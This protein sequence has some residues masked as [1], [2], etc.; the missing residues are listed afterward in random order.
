LRW[1]VVTVLLVSVVGYSLAWAD[2]VDLSLEVFCGCFQVDGLR[3]F[4][5]R[6][7]LLFLCEVCYA[8]LKF[9]L[10]QEPGDYRDGVGHAEDDACMGASVTQA[11]PR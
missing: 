4:L 3:C 5:P 1:F 8:V 7:V 6:F 2:R 9:W 11:L 10:V